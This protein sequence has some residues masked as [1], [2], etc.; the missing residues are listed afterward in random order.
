MRE[1][2]QRVE[3]N[4]LEGMKNYEEKDG[5]K[6]PASLSAREYIAMKACTLSYINEQLTKI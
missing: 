2:N 5:L 6:I 4:C 3:L 1:N